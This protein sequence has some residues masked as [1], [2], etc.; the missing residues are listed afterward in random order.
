MDIIL[1]SLAGEFIPKSLSVLSAK[2]RFV[3]IGK[4]GVWEPSQVAYLKPDVSY[5]VFDLVE[6]TQQQPASIQSMLRQLMQQFQVG[7]LKPLPHKQFPLNRV[8]DAFRYMQQA[9]HIG[10]IVGCQHSEIHD[11][12]VPPSLVRGDGTYLITGGRS[13]R[14]RVT[15]SSM[16]GRTASKIPGIGRAQ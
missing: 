8:V 10:K 11:L 1:N 16:A 13:G 3:E 12:A 15:S 9:K 14:S 4:Q 6:M 2:G 5:F 7:S